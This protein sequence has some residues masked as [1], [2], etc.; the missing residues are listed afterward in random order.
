M[1]GVGYVEDVTSDCQFCHSGRRLCHFLEEPLRREGVSLDQPQQQ[2]L[3]MPDEPMDVVGANHQRSLPEGQLL[4]SDTCEHVRFRHD[5][6]QR[7]LVVDGHS[8]RVGIMLQA[9]EHESEEALDHNFRGDIN[10]SLCE[11]E[12]LVRLVDWGGEEHVHAI[13]VSGDAH[14]DEDRGVDAHHVVPRHERRELAPLV[15]E[16]IHQ[17]I[18]VPAVGD[19]DAPC[20][21]FVNLERHD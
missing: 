13:R 16:G 4:R 12:E 1:D 14:R 2:A 9:L 7:F 15:V 5:E 11:E 20:L 17:R 10:I 18:P 19:V 3:R 8:H 6:I 21:W